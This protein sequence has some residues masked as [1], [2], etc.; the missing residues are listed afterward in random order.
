MMS[1]DRNLRLS[2]RRV[3]GSGIAGGLLMLFQL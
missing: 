3:S 1:V 2:A